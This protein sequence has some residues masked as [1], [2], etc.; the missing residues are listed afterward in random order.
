MEAAPL[1]SITVVIRPAGLGR[2][3]PFIHCHSF[4]V[5]TLPPRKAAIHSVPL[6][7]S[8][9]LSFLHSSFGYCR[10]LRFPSLLA[11]LSFTSLNSFTFI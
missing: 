11:H 10:P 2:F 8:V 3:T 4:T 6:T 5:V 7:H 1:E 9:S